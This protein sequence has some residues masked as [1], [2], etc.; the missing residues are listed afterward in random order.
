MFSARCIGNHRKREIIGIGSSGRR[1]CPHG[2]AAL[3]A[4]FAMEIAVWQS[5]PLYC[6]PSGQLLE[7]LCKVGQP[8]AEASERL[9][10]RH[11]SEMRAPLS[12]VCLSRARRVAEEFKGRVP[13]DGVGGR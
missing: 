6:D 1:R 3:R 9:V 11:H 8:V 2:R 4:T 10:M 7:L 12:V 5:A 13:G